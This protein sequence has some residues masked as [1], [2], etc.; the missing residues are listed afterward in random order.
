MH[1]LMNAAASAATV[2]R[3]EDAPGEVLGRRGARSDR[4]TSAVSQSNAPSA[5]PTVSSRRSLLAC[6]AFAGRSRYARPLAQH[7]GGRESRRVDAD[8]TDVAPFARDRLDEEAPHRVVA[9]TR[10]QTRLQAEARAAERRVRRRSAEILCEGRHVLEACADL[11]RVEIDA[12]AAET[13]DVVRTAFREARSVLH[14][15]QYMQFPKQRPAWICF[16]GAV[17]RRSQ[18]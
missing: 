8:V 18:C 3:A 4:P 15:S 2:V 1:E 6:T 13:Q 5:Q 12:E 16:R 11:L 9:D 17:C 10:N 7:D 14:K